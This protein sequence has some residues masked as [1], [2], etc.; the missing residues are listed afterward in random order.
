MDV[1]V[2]PEE[3]R[4]GQGGRENVAGSE[5]VASVLVVAAAS[6]SGAAFPRSRFPERRSK[7]SERKF[8]F[9]FLFFAL[10]QRLGFEQGK[11]KSAFGKMKE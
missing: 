9:F 10:F 3:E 8:F 6:A 7:I 4:G 5:L 2:E 1:D 11:R